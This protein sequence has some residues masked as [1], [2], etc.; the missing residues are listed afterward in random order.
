[1]R[2]K[3]YSRIKTKEWR[4]KNP[5]KAREHRLKE[6]KLYNS[7]H[8]ER[9]KKSKDLHRYG[10]NRDKVLERDNW[11]CQDCGM[12]QEQH[13]IL[14]NRGLTIH[15]KD[16]TGYNSKIKNNDLDNLITLCMRCHGKRDGVRSLET[17]KCNKKEGVK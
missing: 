12:S 1:M 3:E 7:R 5:E 14:F 9:V 6:H 11:Q 15:H 4:K 17:R 16:G 13:I 10:G 2:D 8:P